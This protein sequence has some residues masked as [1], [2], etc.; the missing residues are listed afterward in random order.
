M[1]KYLR[2]IAKKGTNTAVGGENSSQ[3]G[4]LNIDDVNDAPGNRDFAAK[5]TT[6]K[7]E[8]REGNGDDVFKGK[9]KQVKHGYKSPEDKKVY[10]A[11][12]ED[13]APKKGKDEEDDEEDEDEL[14]EAKCN[15]TEAG[16]MCEVHGD[17]DCSSNGKMPEAKPNGKRGMIIDKNKN[18]PFVNKK[19]SEALRKIYEGAKTKRMKNNKKMET[20]QAAPSDTPMKLSYPSDE[21]GQVGRV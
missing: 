9:T 6:Q 15:M 17:K 5:H 4:K 14:N 19:K 8:D 3:K 18:I 1:A 20:E 16:K 11:T 21:V 12:E 2:E 7:W 10:E 13:E